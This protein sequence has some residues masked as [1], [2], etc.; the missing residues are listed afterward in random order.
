MAGSLTSRTLARISFEAAF[1]PPA[2]VRAMRH[3]L[4][5]RSIANSG[6]VAFAG[7]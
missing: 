4:R 7:F 5:A 6:V 3:A 2:I 1:E